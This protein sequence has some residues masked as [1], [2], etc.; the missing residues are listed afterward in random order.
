M[1]LEITNL[2]GI[3]GTMLLYSLSF[4]TNQGEQFARC[5]QNRTRHMNEENTRFV[6]RVPSSPVPH[7]LWTLKIS[8]DTCESSKHTPYPAGRKVNAPTSI[9]YGEIY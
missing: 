6:Q 8:S 2:D 1:N 3:D 4:S 9:K 7:E 5:L